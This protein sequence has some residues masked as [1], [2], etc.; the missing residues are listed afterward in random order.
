MVGNSGCQ[1]FHSQPELANVCHC[2]LHLRPHL[3]PHSP[4]TSP[5]TSQPISSRFPLQLCHLFQIHI[6]N[7]S[8][9]DTPST[10]TLCSTIF[11][12]GLFSLQARQ[13]FDWNEH[14]SDGECGPGIN[15][16]AV[17]IQPVPFLVIHH[18]V[19]QLDHMLLRNVNQSRLRFLRLMND[20]SFW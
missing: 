1:V 14:L 2:C 3:F 9:C 18:D 15:N 12:F 7:A 5:P 4:L 10:I 6:Q 11:N 8:G 20:C 16:Q 17:F 13:L 19:T